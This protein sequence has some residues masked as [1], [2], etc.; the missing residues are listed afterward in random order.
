VLYEVESFQCPDANDLGTAVAIE[1]VEEGSNADRHRDRRDW[2]WA[3]A[4]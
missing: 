4:A 2:R 1:A 3:P